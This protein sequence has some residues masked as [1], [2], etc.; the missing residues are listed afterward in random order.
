MRKKKKK[1]KK[2]KVR[3]M[4]H[5]VGHVDRFGSDYYTE[6]DVN[7][8]SVVDIRQNNFDDPSSFKNNE[9]TEKTK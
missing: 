6:R 9:Y 7:S 2:K 3:D 8:R 1:K 5:E 4:S